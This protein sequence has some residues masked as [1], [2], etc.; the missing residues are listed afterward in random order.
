MFPIT[1]PAN[2]ANPLHPAN[3][4]NPASPLYYGHRRL[5]HTTT[6]QELPVTDHT[7]T[8]P[9]FWAVGLFAALMI[10]SMILSFNN[11]G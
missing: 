1:S 6:T 8:F 10:L 4:V 9:V 3:P 5:Q 7:D 2:P 11:K